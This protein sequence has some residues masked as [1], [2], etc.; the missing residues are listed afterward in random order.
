MYHILIRIYIIVDPLQIMVLLE[1]LLFFLLALAMSW[2]IK[3]FHFLNVAPKP[4][5]NRKR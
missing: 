2:D 5:K 4:W 3:S 1:E